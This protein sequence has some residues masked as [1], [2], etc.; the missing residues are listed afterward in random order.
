MTSIAAAGNQSF[1]IKADGQR[2]GQLWAWGY[3]Q[4]NTL[5]DGLAVD[6]PIAVHTLDDVKAV[7]AGDSLASLYIKATGVAGGSAVWGSGYHNAGLLHT[8]GQTVTVV[9]EPVAAGSFVSV[10]VGAGIHALR[11]DGT[12]LSWGG[13][14][15]AVNGLA[16]GDATWANTDHDGDGLR[17]ADEWDI[18][19]DPWSADSNEDGIPDGSA[20]AM[21][22]D[23]LATDVDSDTVPNAVERAQGTD[24]FRADTDGDG[25][26]DGA[27]AYPLDPTRW[28][29]PPPTGGDTTA[30][31]VTLTEPTS[32]TLVSVV[33]AP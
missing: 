5:G 10:A 19:T 11:T 15:P 2:F 12:L 22:V 31:L 9:P 13:A 7:F 6:Q 17:T 20:V 33:P 28:D 27:D 32:A 21:G 30:P 1:A 29:G 16:L 26:P 14:W 24:P 8:G 18:G 4:N 25:H 3:N 23:P